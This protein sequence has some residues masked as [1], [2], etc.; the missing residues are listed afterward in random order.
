MRLAQIVKVFSATMH[1]EREVL[2]E[3]VTTWL[4]SPE[5]AKLHI[6]EIRTL[7]SSDS[8][9]HCT[10]IIVLGQVEVAS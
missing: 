8:E 2:G 1:K 7:Q 3:K 6:D 5:Q 9:F 4:R 10:T